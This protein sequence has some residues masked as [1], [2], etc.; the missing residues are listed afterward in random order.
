MADAKAFT[1]PDQHR[2]FIENTLLDLLRRT[3][4]GC[5]EWICSTD[6]D[7]YGSLTC[8]GRTYRVHRLAYH[9]YCGPLEPGECVCHRCDNPACCNPAHLFRGTQ[10]VN[11]YDRDAKGRGP[12]GERNHFAKTT[13]E[14]AARVKRLLASGLNQT[15]VARECGLTRAIVHSIARGKAWAHVA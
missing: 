9:L 13:A 7:G 5:W 8:C 12:R 15:A 10:A 6:K 1:V 2:R 4:Y 11:T 3:P 14:T